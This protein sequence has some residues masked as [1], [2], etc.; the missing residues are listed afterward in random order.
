MPR[1]IQCPQ[2][3]GALNLSTAILGRNSQCTRC[4]AKLQ[5]APVYAR[6][7]SVFSMVIGVCLMCEFGVRAFNIFVFAFP[8]WFLVLFVMVRVV[9]LIVPPRLE[10]RDSSSFTTLSLTDRAEEQNHTGRTF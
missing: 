9:P 2:C 4:G 10:L 1:R 7:L 3:F 5:I 6:V 8:M